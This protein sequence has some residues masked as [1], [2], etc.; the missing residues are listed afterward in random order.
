MK[1]RT[2][3]IAVVALIVLACALIADLIVAEPI[4]NKGVVIGMGLDKTERG[5]V[6]VTIQIA[7]AGESSA[8]GAPNRYAVVS[9]EAPTL[10]AAMDEI[11][12]ITAYKPAYFHCHILLVGEKLVTEGVKE[13]V[14]ELFAED[15]V[16]DGVAIM[17]VEGT[18]KETIER[19][20]SMQGAA[21]VYLQ[22]LNKLNSTS[23]GHPTATLRSFVTAFETAGYTPYLP[24]VTAV[25]VP[26]A[27]GGADTGGD[28]QNYAFD[29]AKTVLFT[30][31]GIGTVE[32]EETTVAIGLTGQTEG[33]LLPIRTEEGFMDVF[34]KKSLHLWHIEKS[35][36][37]T[38]SALY[39]VKVIATDVKES[40]NDLP[41]TF[42]AENVADYARR[43][44][45]SA[46]ARGAESGRDP[47]SL[48]GKY[49]KKYGDKKEPSE[50]TL[51]VKIAVKTSD[52]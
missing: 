35:G 51:Q 32:S 24:W 15:S 52:V 7:V 13:V 19:S 43:T 31:D 20:V 42:V 50:T 3:R 5:N 14:T 44:I 41:E 30:D 46:Y 8:P 25:P 18:A 47:Y 4:L 40:P 1:S 6:E 36:A 26:K 2:K 29:C 38:L 23:G 27:I 22:Q 39:F 45:L 11:A 48:K 16:M 34:V 37:V 28:E 9:G 12:R 49:H 17:A 33:M 10:I 21:S